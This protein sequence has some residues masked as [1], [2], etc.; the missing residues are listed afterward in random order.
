MRSN[1]NRRAIIVGIF[2][3]LGVAIFIWTVLTLGSQKNTFQ[4]SIAVKTFFKNVNGLQKGNNI[5]FSGVKVGTVENVTLIGNE[6]VEVDMNINESSVP[7]IH[8]NAKAKLST[9]G[10][11]GNKIIEIYGGSS[12]APRI[13]AGDVL[14][15]EELL[16]T[17]QMMATLSKNN[18]NL[19]AITDNLKIISAQMAE[20]KGSVGK[21]LKDETFA[22]ELTKT[23]VTLKSA[24]ANL[25]Q[26]SANVSHYTS[27][28]NDSGTLANDLVSDTVIFS[29]LRA[30][31]GKLQQMADSSTAVIKSLQGAAST[32]NEGLKNPNTP[33]GMLLGDEKTASSLKTTMQNLQSASVKLNDDLEAVQHNFL[34]RGFFRKKAKAEKAVSETISK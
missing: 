26:L 34:L 1:G 16:S 22:D 4:K 21:L 19:L 32:V 18:D 24:A 28:L 2:I 15:N 12:Q 6:K 33:A 3:F 14:N 31:V 9:D 17:D 8:K 29:K 23:V 20:G 10:L 5:W 25:Q 7:Y 27:R 13:S 11:I 30:T